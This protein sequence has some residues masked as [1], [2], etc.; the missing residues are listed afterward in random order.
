MSGSAFR[1]FAVTFPQSISTQSCWKPSVA[2][3]AADRSFPAC[4]D[5]QD[6]YL[7]RREVALLVV[8][9]VSRRVEDELTIEASGRLKDPFISSG[10]A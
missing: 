10:R 4:F 7:S 8:A 2:V 6:S 5:P 9:L 3:Y 1:R